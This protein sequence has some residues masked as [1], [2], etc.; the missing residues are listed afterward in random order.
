MTYT[1]YIQIYN[2]HCNTWYI[3]RYIT[4][5]NDVKLFDDDYLL[6]LVYYIRYSAMKI[7]FTEFLM[8]EN[9]LVI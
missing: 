2:I 3:S 7:I 8:F 4:M 6:T 9:W 5:I 1:L